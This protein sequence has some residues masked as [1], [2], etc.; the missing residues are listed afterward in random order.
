MLIFTLPFPAW[1]CPIYVDSWTQRSRFLCNIVLYST[2]LYFH[3]QTHPPLS[4]ISALTQP[5][6]SSGAID[7]LFPS[8]ILDTFWPRGLIFW[9]HI[10]FPFSYHPWSS[11]GKNTG[12]CC[13]FLLQW[14][15]FCKNSSVWFLC[16]G[17]SYIARLIGSL[18]YASPF[19][20]ARL[21]SQHALLSSLFILYSPDPDSIVHSA[22]R[23]LHLK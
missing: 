16:L 15:M 7:P 9:C 14:I 21:W 17:W 10:F 22:A 6:Y 18:S 4:I 13:H 20:M 1:P 19:T 5:L 23:V 8:S 3:H 2:G 12:G 11:P